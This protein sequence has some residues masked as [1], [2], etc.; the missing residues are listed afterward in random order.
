[1][2]NGTDVLA[3]ATRRR[4]PDTSPRVALE[5]R[6]ET[7]AV[8]GCDVREGLEADHRHGYSLGGMTSLQN[9]ARLCRH[10]HRLKTTK[11][12]R[13]EGRP[14]AWRWVGPDPPDP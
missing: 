14:G 8:P 12:W 4:G 7:C 3:V 13:L 9:L 5:A 1:V 10:H 2:E 6:D 11:G